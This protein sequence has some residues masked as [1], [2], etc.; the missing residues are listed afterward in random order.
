MALGA[1][2]VTPWQMFGAYAVFANGGYKVNP[3]LID[4]ITDSNGTEL[5]HAAPV[6]VSDE[7]N[8]V[9]D[10]RNAFIMDSMLK[11]VVRFGTGARAG[12]VLKRSDIAGKTGTTNE[13]RDAWFDGYANGQEAAVTWVGYDQPQSLG[14]HEFANGV[15]LPIWISYM[16]AVLK[17]SAPIDRPVPEGLLTI[18][19]EYYYA[20]YPP[21][22]DSAAEQTA[23]VPNTN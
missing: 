16:Q 23:P 22:Q 19:G 15:A 12:A 11:G 14:S 13:A 8:R 7:A 2:S 21:A 6:K 3:Y 4:R 20:E 10:A 18:N 17:G 1:G 5:A 9:I